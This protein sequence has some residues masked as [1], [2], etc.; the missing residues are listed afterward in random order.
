M[1]PISRSLSLALAIGL[2]HE[3]VRMP[4]PRQM[5]AACL[6][7]FPAVALARL[8]QLLALPL[9]SVERSLVVPVPGRRS[10]ADSVARLVDSVARRR[11]ARLVRSQGPW[12]RLSVPMLARRLGLGL[13]ARSAALLVVRSIGSSLQNQARRVARTWGWIRPIRLPSPEVKT[14]R[15]Y[16]GYPVLFKV[17]PSRDKVTAPWA[18]STMQSP[19]WIRV[20][21]GG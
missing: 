14:H 7:A 4:Q 6:G 13:G 1:S 16:I 15:P 19:A 21:G 12:V 20:W 3:P 2:Y 10:A 9:V 18:G 5:A 8:G 11:V 17:R